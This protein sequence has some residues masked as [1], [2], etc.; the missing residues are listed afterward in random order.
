MLLLGL[1]RTDLSPPLWMIS[2]F[3]GAEAPSPPVSAPRDFSAS[4]PRT[5]LDN[6]EPA[7]AAHIQYSIVAKSRFSNTVQCMLSLSLVPRLCT[8]PC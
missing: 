1:A 5:S 7:T 3:E 6:L 2:Y 8:T 4:R